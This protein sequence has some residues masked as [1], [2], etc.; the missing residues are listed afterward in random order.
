MFDY[1]YETDYEEDY[2]NRWEEEMQIKESRE[3]EQAIRAKAIKASSDMREKATAIWR[4]TEFREIQR[5]VNN[6]CVKDWEGYYVFFEAPESE[7]EVIQYACKLFKT[8]PDYLY[9]LTREY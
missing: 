9:E 6:S 1:D 2:D 3:L 7:D 4:I 5:I 8:E